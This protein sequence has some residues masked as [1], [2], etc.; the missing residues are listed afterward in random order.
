[1]NEAAILDFLKNNPEFLLTHAKSLGVQP[2]HEKI[3]AFAEVKLQANEIRT[4]R[5]AQ[6]LNEVID[7]A[8]HNQALI[9]T[10]FALDHAL[11][12]ATSLNDVTTAL[13]TALDQGFQLPQYALRL[14]PQAHMTLPETELLKPNTPTFEK[15]K[16]L[17]R[18]VCDHYLA[19]DVL[20]WLPK[21]AETLQSFL[22]VP[23]LG[24]T[25]DFIGI[26]IVASPNPKHFG[27]EQDTHYMDHLALSLSAALN[28]ILTLANA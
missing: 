1:M 6:H 4:E 9:E 18:S 28:R 26:L 20:A 21:S 8:R 17:K 19:D 14:V 2:S 3:T 24:P 23:L 5:M 12:A 25:Q 27:P 16:L 10:L 22:K 15:F 7:N 13:H 11:I